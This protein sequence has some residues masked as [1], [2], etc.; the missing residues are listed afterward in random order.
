MEIGKWEQI[1][2]TVSVKLQV[3]ITR[4]ALRIMEHDDVVKGVPIVHP[5]DNLFWFNRPKLLLNLIH[6]VLFQN[7]FQ[8]AFFVWS[9]V[10]KVITYIKALTIFRDQLFIH[11]NFYSDFAV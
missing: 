3:I 7:A 5:A 6:F 10:S 2:L 8:V 9:W 4:M 1:I 11:S